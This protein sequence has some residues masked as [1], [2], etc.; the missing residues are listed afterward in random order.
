MGYSVR[1]DAWRYTIWVAWNGDL[2][3]PVWQSI[4]GTELFEHKTLSGDF[5]GEYSEPFNRA[6]NP[7]AEAQA[8]MTKLHRI[9]IAQ[10]SR[11]A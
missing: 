4:Q 11:D 2:L 10:F 5:D 9:L 3:K 8:T 7:D 1:S 6:V